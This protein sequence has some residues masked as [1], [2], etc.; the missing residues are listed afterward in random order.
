V[1]AADDSV[2]V[3]FDRPLDEGSVLANG[4][5]FT[6]DMGLTVSAAVASGDTVTLTTSSQ[7]PSTS[8]TVTVADTVTDAAGTGVDSSFNTATFSGFTT[9]ATIVINEVNAN[10]PVGCDLV[11]IR[12][13]T[14]G[15]IGGHQLWQRQQAVM[16]FPEM[17]LAAGEFVVI[18]LGSLTNCNMTGAVNETSSPS[19]ADQAT[20]PQNYDTAYDLYAD[21]GGL[22]ATSNVLTLVNPVGAI[23]DA[24]LLHNDDPNVAGTSEARAAEVVAASQWTNPDGMVPSGGYID[25][26]FITGGV[27][28]L[29]ATDATPGG[30][31]IQRTSDTDDDDR[32]D[33]T[34]APVTSTWGAQNAGQ[35]SP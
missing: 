12:A 18:H 8:Y 2:L 14:A 6:I 23:V 17:S 26:D 9:P 11:E 35:S 13:L 5:Q 27:P 22:T 24:V 16:T 30:T 1:A 28:G 33:W 4:S 29:A 21:A 10:L 34:S 20:H 32:D 25:A 15:A 31:S 7:T 3:T 19:S